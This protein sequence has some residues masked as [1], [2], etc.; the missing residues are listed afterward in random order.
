KDNDLGVSDALLNSYLENDICAALQTYE[1]LK[2]MHEKYINI[3]ESLLNEMGYRLL[4][5]G[6]ITEAIALLSV[7]TAVYPDSW[8]AFDSLG[9]AYMKA[10][11][12]EAATMCYRR[13]LELNPANRNAADVLI[14][15]DSK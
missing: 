6:R 11:D 13:S 5:A 2:R 12:A 15:L 4:N 7:V 14:E 8:N 3:D 1:Q 9:E 10:G